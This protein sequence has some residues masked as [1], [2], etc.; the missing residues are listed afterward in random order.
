MAVNV[1]VTVSVPVNAT[2]FK[3]LKGIQGSET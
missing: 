2:G 3:R 1:T